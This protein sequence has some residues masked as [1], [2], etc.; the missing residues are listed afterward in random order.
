MSLE[1]KRA[2]DAAHRD[3]GYRVL[4]DRLWPRGVSKDDASID[5]WPKEAAPSDTL[6]KAFH[7]GD[8][9]WGE[10]R[11]RYLGELKAHRE[12]LR[13]LARRALKERVTLV[14]AA[15]D[16]RHNNARV[17]AEYLAMLEPH[18]RAETR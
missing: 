15:K 12:R 5:E 10:F 9:G 13:P 7:A 6:R 8:Y 1:L 4:V 2:F 17:L 18:L 16:E 3:D 14:F 11:R